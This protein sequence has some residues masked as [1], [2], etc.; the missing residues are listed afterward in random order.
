MAH[1]A[2]PQS[3]DASPNRHS[4]IGNGQRSPT[5]HSHAPATDAHIDDAIP[6]GTTYLAGSAVGEGAEVTFSSDGGI[7]VGVSAASFG[8]CWSRGLQ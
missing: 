7:A 2:N 5:A 4:A 8:K 3:P 6:K 1:C